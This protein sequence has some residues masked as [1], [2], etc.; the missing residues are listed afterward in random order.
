MGNPKEKEQTS[1]G[2]SGN[3]ALSPKD[4][5]KA[6]RDL[7][8]ERD[9]RD[10]VLAKQV[11]EAVARE[12]AK[13]QM[14]Y[15]ALL[16]ESKAAM[17]T[18]LKMN[19]RALG[20]KVM[21]PFDWTKDKAIYQQW[22][23]WSEKARHALEAMEDDSEKTKISYFHHWIDSEGVAKIESWKNSKTLISQEDYQKL[24]ENE[25]KDKYS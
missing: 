11:A 16:N 13:A 5:H 25:K 4:A 9:A 3:D 1:E 14:H 15:Q 6:N 22:Q 23:M 21:D 20:F 24:E 2:A 8:W 18:S 7:S 10:T 17:P 19:S 12:M